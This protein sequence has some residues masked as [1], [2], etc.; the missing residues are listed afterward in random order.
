MTYNI[1]LLPFDNIYYVVFF[2]MLEEKVLEILERPTS[3]L[4]GPQ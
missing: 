1:L 4:A 2:F 3:A